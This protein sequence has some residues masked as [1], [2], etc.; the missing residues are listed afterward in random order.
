MEHVWLPI[1]QINNPVQFF[2]QL[3]HVEFEPDQCVPASLWPADMPPQYGIV[4]KC[5]TTPTK[6]GPRMAVDGVTRVAPDDRGPG[7]MPEA[8]VSASPPVVAGPLHLAD[9]EHEPEIAIQ[10]DEEKD[11]SAD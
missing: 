2:C 9:V 1:L 8:P 5:N 11:L 4:S 10:V 6:R 3:C 7:A